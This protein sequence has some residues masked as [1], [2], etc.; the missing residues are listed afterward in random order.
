ML[1][2][3]LFR[4]GEWVQ[5]CY[6]SIRPPQQTFSRYAERGGNPELIRESQRRRFE[7]VAVVDEVI[8][9]DEEWR[10]VHYQ[11][12]KLNQ[13]LNAV[14]K[15]VAI[16]SKAKTAPPESMLIESRSIKS[17]IAS[18]ELK[19]TEALR[20]RD[21]VLLTI[22]NLVE[23]D[24]PVSRD[25]ADNLVLGEGG[26]ERILEPE[27]WMLSHPDLLTWLGMV[28]LEAA[29][30]VSGGRTYYLLGEGVLLN[31]ALI[32]Y[33]LRF[34]VE[35]GFQPVATPHFM[36]RDVMSQVAQID[37][38]DT[39]L[40]RLASS[41]RG[42]ADQGKMDPPSSSNIGGK[43]RTKDERYLIA[44]SEQ[45]LCGLHR[46]SWLEAS[47]LPIRYAGLSTCYRR[48]AGSHGK[49]TLGI[50]RVHQF[51]KVEMLCL[52]Q[53]NQSRR[54]MEG[55]VRNAGDFYSTL[56]IPH[57]WV[58]VASG[59]LNKAAA[60]KHDLEA[61]FPVSKAYRELVS[62]S[63]CT[64]YQARA[65][66][67]RVRSGKGEGAAG[68]KGSHAHILNS[69]LTATQRTLSCLIEN[70]QTKE[71]VR[72]PAPLQPFLNCDFIPFKIPLPKGK[73]LF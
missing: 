50:F 73:R 26:P 64:D 22:G 49:D 40:Y 36:R 29:Q 9:L 34:L 70:H 62:C 14:S 60:I 67:I 44:T 21:Q 56:G 8:R 46:K 1:D 4:Q 6:Q 35:R 53:A 15:Q 37:E 17:E 30:S 10:T 68:G 51:D 7:D 45:P 11:L 42:E 16:L 18:L 28:N 55:L 3:N 52:T 72:V 71:G 69:T 58:S 33:G 39:E 24:V 57:R 32:N 63:N 19:E 47:S 66:D 54:E 65:L 13:K 2:I 20:V 38:F 43:E 5:V 23:D 12:E 48:E 59:A 31:Q 41:E 27:P 25:E 61:W